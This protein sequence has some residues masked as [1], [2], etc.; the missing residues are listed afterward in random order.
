M[1]AI[2]LLQ[3][4]IDI[5]KLMDHYD[6]DNI[7]HDGLM[8]RS[9]CKLHG[10]KNPSGFVAN[11]ENGLFYCHTGACG[12]GD[13]FTLVQ[14]MEKCT[15]PDAVNWTAKFFG[16]DIDGLRITE[17]NDTHL[18]E[19]KLFVKAM[20]SRKKREV[21]EY[22]IDEEIK[23]VTKFRSFKG[24]TLKLFG[25]GHVVEITASKRNGTIYKLKNR[26]V[27]PIIQDGV[28]IGASLR[29][30]KAIDIPKWSHQPSNIQTKEILYNYDNAIG[31]S[32]IVIV[33]GIPDVWA[34]H[35]IG[36][37]AVCTFGAHVTEEQYKLLIRTG[38]DLVL[39]FDGDE[40]G[41]LAT[42]KVIVLFRYKA[43]MER[44]VFSEGEDPENI[45]REE[46]M[47]R[48]ESKKRV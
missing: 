43:N 21:S 5:T 11:Q 47:H 44:V 32:I 34:Y 18:K 22:V 14:H 15:F 13:A 28:Q 16:V 3:E 39:S 42:E 35:E 46:L 19:L 26:L 7:R 24:E 38:A 12:G 6:F 9:C 48:Y 1:D 25:L 45:S 8:I 27:F 17:R 37:T 29:R 23:Q 40:A 31:K 20:R 10:G 36:V 33:E 4:H 41:T 2:T 30:V